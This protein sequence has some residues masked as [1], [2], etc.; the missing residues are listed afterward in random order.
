MQMRW[1]DVKGQTSVT[2]LECLIGLNTI[3]IMPESNCD[4]RDLV[5]KAAIAAMITFLC[6]RQCTHVPYYSNRLVRY[7]LSHEKIK[8]TLPAEYQEKTA[9]DNIINS[10]GIENI[11]TRT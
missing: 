7:Y 9:L 11:N 2:L 6:P 1:I 10:V 5:S 8:T 4:A 3:L